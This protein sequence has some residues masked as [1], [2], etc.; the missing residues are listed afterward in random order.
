MG[1]CFVQYPFLMWTKV[2]FHAGS[3]P[4]KGIQGTDLGNEI[5]IYMFVI[6]Y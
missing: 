3:N 1:S 5:N 2:A 4:P 6:C